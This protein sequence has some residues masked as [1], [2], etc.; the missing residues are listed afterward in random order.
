[1]KTRG[2]TTRAETMHNASVHAFPKRG[3]IGFDAGEHP[4]NAFRCEAVVGAHHCVRIASRDPQRVRGVE[5]TEAGIAISLPRGYASSVLPV[6]ATVV[7]R[8]GRWTRGSAAA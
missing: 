2:K 6:Q 5:R 4:R 8:V 3:A 1:M 7:G